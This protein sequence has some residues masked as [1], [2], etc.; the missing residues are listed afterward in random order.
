MS[1]PLVFIEIGRFLKSY[2]K[3]NRVVEK[4]VSSFHAGLFRFFCKHIHC[5]HHQRVLGED[6]ERKVAVG[7]GMEAGRV[8]TKLELSEAL[9]LD[10]QAGF[11]WLSLS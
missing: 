7:L 6:V 10:R 11:I 8:G 5:A 9:S 2:P 1:C 3:L 4:T